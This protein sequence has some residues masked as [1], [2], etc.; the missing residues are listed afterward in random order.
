VSDLD[1]LFAPRSVALVGAS[2]DAAKPAGIALGNLARFRGRVYPVNPRCEELGG[3]A[4]YRSV[5]ELPETVDLSVVMR[6]A[7]E[8]PALVR[9][10]RGKARCVLVVSAGFAETGS[11]EL[12]EDLARAGREAGV[13]LLGPNCLGVYNPFR[14][15][16]T[17]FLPSAG[18]RR[19]RRGKVAVV[20]QSGAVLVSILDALGR[21]GIGVSRAANYGN[22]VDIDAPEIYDW[23]ARDEET[24]VVIAYLES[25]GDGRRFVAAARCLAAAKQFLL[26]KGG[27]G[28]SGQA[29]AF[30]H[31]GRLAGSY[32]VF[33]SILGQ[34]GIREAAEFD[35]LLDA[36][37]ALACRRPTPGNRVCIITNAGGAGVL[38]AD[39]CQRRGLATPP[40]PEAAAAGLRAALPSFYTIAN[41][42]DLTGQVRAADYRLTLDAVRNDFDGFLVIALT[43]VAGVTL[44]LAPIFREFTAYAA[45]PLVVHI[46]QGGVA[47]RLVP[48][49]EKACIPVYPS[50]ERAVRGLRALLTEKWP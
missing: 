23:L 33:H 20:S 22:A 28:G 39:E 29:A 46:A 19:P 48:L 14:R 31:T 26:L 32:E 47:G 24:G 3:L 30:S 18:M 8:V 36:A 6:P 25:V 45:K 5:Q 49:L 7:A 15:L 17:F 16:D 10:H 27:K 50:P 43:G 21:T 42:I 11:G 40:L 12:Q 13:R 4:C 34:F 44:D 41:P 37:H 38:A 2:G 9:E 1:Y 35:E